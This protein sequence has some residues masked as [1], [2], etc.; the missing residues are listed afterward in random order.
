MY[1]G[2]NANILV[3]FLDEMLVRVDQLGQLATTFDGS[4]FILTSVNKA[5]TMQLNRHEV[6]EDDNTE[7]L[8]RPVVMNNLAN[9]ELKATWVQFLN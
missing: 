6:E 8:D 7:Q 2:I 5:F 9:G 3:A 1:F 4:T